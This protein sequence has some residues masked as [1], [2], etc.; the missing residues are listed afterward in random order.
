[1]LHLFTLAAMLA[2]TP[3]ASAQEAAPASPDLREAVQQLQQQLNQQ[4]EEL[5]E[6]KKAL[7]PKAAAP[8]SGEASQASRI[9][10]FVEVEPQ[11]LVVLGLEREFAARNN[12][13]V[14]P[15]PGGG[16]GLCL[17]ASGPWA[18]VG[19]EDI[20]APKI[21]AGVVSRDGEDIFSIGGFHAQSG[22]GR[23]S[24]HGGNVFGAAPVEPFDEIT[25]PNGNNQPLPRSADAEDDF[26]MDQLDFDYRR[27]ML[28]DDLEVTPELGFRSLFF[29]NELK[30]TFN[31]A[32]PGFT[33]SLAR[34]SRSA[35]F[36]P[37]AG[38]AAD[39]RL[40]GPFSL[41]A[42]GLSGYLVGY[43]ESEQTLC[44][45]SSFANP[46]CGSLH[47]FRRRTDQ[48]FPFIEG[49][50]ALQYKARRTGRLSAAAGYRIAS[51]FGLVT[52]PETVGNSL[53]IAGSGN[54]S[55][56]RDIF[57]RHDVAISSFFFRLQ[58]LF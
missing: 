17:S 10:F 20:F 54:S 44:Q 55:L 36:G 52:L 29:K 45:G 13:A 58:Y 51:Y 24:F 46:G 35:G 53:D 15:D 14:C 5:R 21:T 43:S 4:Q 34:A 25:N 33:F 1:M 42:K 37:K 48:G 23:A 38:L 49:E 26:S 7:P 16:N 50:F 3:P 41:K 9:R 12:T 30:T 6:L 2:M 47:S 8:A 57:Q 18:T 31:H 11:W 27:P 22:G 19:T 28:F 40:V 56:Q 39:R 32:N